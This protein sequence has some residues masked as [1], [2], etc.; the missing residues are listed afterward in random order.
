MIENG[1]IITIVD[2]DIEVNSHPI[3]SHSIQTTSYNNKTRNSN[4]GRTYLRVLTSGISSLPDPYTLH[5]SLPPIYTLYSELYA[6]YLDTFSPY[7]VF[8]YESNP[9]N[10]NSTGTNSGTY[11]DTE[12]YTETDS[13]TGTNTEHAH[14]CMMGVMH[15]QNPYHGDPAPHQMGQVQK[16]RL[17]FDFGCTWARIG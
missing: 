3:P 9:T 13:G 11:T 4:F 12:T 7:Y 10:P 14:V 8:L 6:P 1:L 5:T 2:T 17:R 15:Q 16:W